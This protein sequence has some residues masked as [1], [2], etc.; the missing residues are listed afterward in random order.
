[1]IT[2]IDHLTR[3]YLG[4]K[5]VWQQTQ[6]VIQDMVDE[7]PNAKRYYSDAYERLW[8]HGG[9]YELSQGKTDTYSVEGDNAELHHLAQ[10]ARRS[11]SFFRDVQKH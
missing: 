6:E 7:A 10:L 9:I 8:Y 3:C 1:V 11:C 2:I 4:L 5:V